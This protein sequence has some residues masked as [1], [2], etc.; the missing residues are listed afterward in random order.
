MS[1]Y[2]EA[3]A[4]NV[5]LIIVDALRPDHLGFYGYP[6]PTSPFLDTL[7]ANSIV[8]EDACANAPW[9]KPAIGTIFTSLM[10]SEHEAIHEG[11]ASRLANSLLTLA[12]VFAT[13][14][15]LRLR[16]FVAGPGPLPEATVAIR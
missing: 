4:P 10:P 11:S 14:A 12:E 13:D 5:V 2:S 8:L 7:A 9:T 15:W 16:A 3:R 1:C 6:E